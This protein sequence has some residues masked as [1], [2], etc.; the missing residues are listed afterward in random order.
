MARLRRSDTSVAGLR[1]LR[2]GRG[3]RYLTADGSRPEL[4][5]LDRIRQLVIPPA[6]TGV[7]ICPYANGH[8]QATGIDAAGRRQYLYHADWRARRDREKHDHVLSVAAGLPAAR[9]A[10]CAQLGERGLTR[11]RVLA[12][13]FILLDVGL[14]RIGGDRYAEENGSYGLMTLQ[15]EHV[16]C[17]RAGLVFDYPAKSGKERMH[18]VT[19]G[20]VV[21]VVRALHRRR[22]PG[23]RRLACTEAGRWRELDSADMNGYLK[24]LFGLDV[25]AKDLRTW[26]A[27]VLAAAGLAVSGE[28][29]RS[30]AARKRA[31]S[32]IVTE[33]SGYLG[34]TPVVC[35]SSYIDPRLFDRYLDGDRVQFPV[36]R[37]GEDAP[38]GWPATHGGFEEA[39]IRLLSG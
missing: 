22:P 24:G 31:V 16:H 13:A 37:L 5:D 36:D 15:R 33:V 12:A 26:H 17:T 8:L 6:W 14:F 35:R 34:N 25:S 28:A 21:A 29:P 18:V 30:P 3:F 11:Q 4:A 32:R 20:S 19:A 9:E 1:R 38:A 10:A 7:W 2:H 39:V 27:T 23:Q